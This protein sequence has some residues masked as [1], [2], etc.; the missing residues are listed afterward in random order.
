MEPRDL[1]VTA[2]LAAL[3][4][5]VAFAFAQVIAGERWVAPLVVAAILP[6]LIG[7]VAR[8]LRLGRGIEIAGS[9]VILAIGILVLTPGGPGEVLD[10]IDTG[11]EVART[12]AAPIPA[13]AGVVILAAIAVWVVASLADQLAFHEDAS[14]GAIAPGVVI[15]IWCTALGDRDAAWLVVGAFG[16]TALLFLGLQHQR[17]L[18]RHR[19]RVGPAGRFVDAPTLLLGGMAV[20][21]LALVASILGGLALPGAYDAL[22]EVGPLV[23]RPFH[24]SRTYTAKVEP[25]LDVGDKLTEPTPTELFTVAADRPQYWRLATYNTYE[26]A[27]GGRWIIY[28]KGDDDTVTEGLDE[29][30]PDGALVQR[31]RIGPAMG[32]R[33][34]PAAYEP[35]RVSDPDILVVESSKTLVTGRDSVAGMT[36]TVKSAVLPSELDAGARRNATG[37]VSDDLDQ[38]RRLPPDLPSVIAETARAIAGSAGD[39]IAQATALR[40]YFRDGSFTYDTSPDLG[41]GGDVAAVERFLRDRRGFCVQFATAYTLMARQ[42]GIPA[43]LAVGFVPGT[44][45]EATST[46]SVSTT[47][48]HAWPE[49]YFAGLGWTNL[50]DPTPPSG[51]TGLAG[52][53]AVP[54]EI[55]PQIQTPV[56]PET[57][58]TTVPATAPPATNG[59]PHTGPPG[60]APPGTATPQGSGVE[61]DATDD[62]SDGGAWIVVLAIFGLVL[63]TVPTVA[64]VLW[65][66]RRRARRRHDVDARRAVVGAWREAMDTFTDHR[67]HTRDSDTPL[68]LSVRI[69]DTIGDAAGPPLHSLAEIYTEA[70]FATDAP[71]DADV[72][73]AWRDVDE[74]R[75]ALGASQGTVARLRAA[76]SPSSLLDEYDRKRDREAELAAGRDSR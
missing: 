13:V 27:Q 53:S 37:A 26:G 65:K 71:A 64:I 61:I 8:A 23:E 25:L 56:E 51:S 48:A 68:E 45:D 21:L 54:N 31:F 34:M 4:L 2:A 69:P 7:A 1:P 5:A 15:V 74:L 3:S 57:P 60:S 70:Q 29:S 63:V 16:A 22:A 49:L 59:S 50:F 46:F 6:H 11:W 72:D 10:R 19:T 52:G 38:Y 44:R 62:E 55:P 35:V 28:T 73:R 14:L 32:E 47:D 36:Y 42:L 12:A 24:G 20:G 18:E 39:P 66:H 30:V 43:R 40:D 67:V 41:D 75:R 58:P 17:L 9:L 76:I 33:F